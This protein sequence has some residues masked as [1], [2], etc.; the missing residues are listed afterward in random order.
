M[1]HSDGKKYYVDKRLYWT[2]P[3]SKKINTQAN[4]GGE[5]TPDNEIQ[6]PELCAGFEIFEKL[7]KNLANSCEIASLLL[8]NSVS[9]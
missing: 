6:Q 9:G 2:P 5:Q 8:D 1:Q 4:D 7:S 3:V